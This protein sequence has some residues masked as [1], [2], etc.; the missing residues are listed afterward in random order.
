ARRRLSS[1]PRRWWQSPCR[2]RRNCL[3][4]VRRSPT[5]TP[6]GLLSCPW[7]T[8][9]TPTPA[10]GRSSHREPG[11]T[12]SPV[13]TRLLPVVVLAVIVAACTGSVATTTT[14]TTVPPAVITTEPDKGPETR[15]CRTRRDP[16][17]RWSAD[18][19]VKPVA[20]ALTLG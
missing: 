3:C 9:S 19:P 11:F 14:P 17:A 12:V 18:A 1:S 16:D 4:T 7:W 13:K 2:R 5:P 6:P 8:G 20:F 10:R 15:W